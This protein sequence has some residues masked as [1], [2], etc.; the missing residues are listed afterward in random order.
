MPRATIDGVSINYEILGSS[1]PAMALSPGGR[2]G[3]ENVLPFAEALARLGYRVLLHDRRN[4]GASDVSFET[5][6]PEYEVWADDL[7]ALADELG[8]LP[9]IAGGSSS[10]ARLALLFA[11]RHPQS[12]RALL[13]WRVTG[14]AFA[15]RRLAEKYY[16]QYVRL[17][18]EGGMAAV[19]AEDHFAEL[20]RNRPSNRDRLMA[21]APDTF[22]AVMEAWRTPFVAGA[23][24]PLVG[25]TEAD[26]RAIEVPVCLI[27]GD[28]R[29]HVSSLAIAAA[30]S[31][32]IARSIASRPSIRTL[33]S[34]R[35]PNGQAGPTRSPR[36]S[37]AFSSAS[38]RVVPSA[39]DAY[40]KAARFTRAAL[41]EANAVERTTPSPSRTDRS[42]CRIRIRPD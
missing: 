32:P 10:G 30:R 5:A 25:T 42:A 40:K 18:R 8:M 22:V 21:I 33:T 17:A 27:P 4:C 16:D 19:C 26:L 6:R 13:L 31:C 2:N 36:S 1:G 11:L 28:D 7:H 34:R 14:G 3:F 20:I 24:M 12:A 41:I 37:T 35:S 9:L 38:S 15:V 39:L 29:T 23:D